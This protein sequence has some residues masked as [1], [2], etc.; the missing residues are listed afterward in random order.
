MFEFVRKYKAEKPL[1]LLLV[2]A[3][4]PRIISIL[5]SKGYGMHDDHY[6]IVE[7]AQSWVD[8]YDYNSWLP[9]NRPNSDPTGH[10]WFYVGLHYYFFLFLDLINLGEPGTKMFIVR[11]LHGFYSLL[12]LPPLYYIGK[13]I[14]NKDLAFK[15]VL[16][17]GLLWFLPILSVRNLVELVSVPPLL[18]ATWLLVKNDNQKIK[19]VVLAGL[20]MGVAMSI[21]LHMSLFIGGIGLVLLFKKRLVHAIVFGISVVVSLF[22]TQIGDIIL[23]GRPFAEIGEYIAYNLANKTSYFNAPWYQYF[24]TIVGLL[25]P[26]LSLVWL[27]GYLGSWKKY[28]LLF[29]PSFIFFAFHCYFPNKQERF[30]LPVFPFL[31]LLGTIGWYRF[32]EKK[33]SDGWRKTNTWFYRIFWGLNIL[34][35]LVVSPSYSKKSRVESMEFFAT[36]PNYQGVIVEYSMEYDVPMLP[37][38]YAQAWNTIFYLSK[39]PEY[40]NKQIEK[41]N[42]RTQETRPNHVLFFEDTDLANR[43]EQFKKTFNCEL[44]Y[45][46]RR[47]PSYLDALLHKLNP[48]NSNETALIYL[49]KYNQ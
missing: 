11:L 41:F 40:T 1:F 21:R 46:T 36:Q 4:I 5:F 44:E 13:Q 45:L 29:W 18:W 48:N 37:R 23:W 24:G 26:P 32:I 39:D 27:I 15:A 49:I 19:N 6:L 14:S 35:L 16:V 28:A 10:S 2:V 12:A 7:A 17:Y 47:E 30:I 38:F 31:V 25:L 43:E 34:L 3:L 22:V 20:L 42:K 33:N 9:K 8:G